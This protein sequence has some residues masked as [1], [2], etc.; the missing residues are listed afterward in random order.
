MLRLL[1]YGLGAGV[2][3]QARRTRTAFLRALDDCRGSQTATLQRL[4]ALHAGSDFSR[5]HRLDGIRT[6]RDFQRAITIADYER[7]RPYVDRMKQGEW[8]A[9]LGT[10]QKPLM[11]ATS[12][13][14]TSEPKFIPISRQYLAD[15]R[16]SWQTWGI[17]FYRPFK[18]M[19]FLHIVQLA[20]DFDR[21]RTPAGTPC[22]NITGFVQHIQN[23]VIRTMYSVPNA[24]LK[25]TNSEAK[26]YAAIRFALADPHVGM[27]MTA[28][29]STLLHLEHLTQQH[30]ESILR[31]IADG[32]LS[33]EFEVADDVR[34]KLR[35]RPRRGRAR[36]LTQR[37]N[38]HGRLSLGTAWDNLQRVAV[39]TAGSAAAYLPRVRAL[40]PGIPIRD[41]GLSASEARMTIT[42]DDETRSAPLD[43]TSHFF[44]FVPEEQIESSLPTVLLAHELEADRNYFIILTTS[45]GLYR[46]D[47]QDVVRCT[48]FQGTTPLIEFLHKG[49]HISNLTGE[50]L[51]ES[52]VVQAVS[53]ACDAEAVSLGYYTL[54]PVW[55]DPPQYRLLV[56]EGDLNAIQR[57][58]LEGEVE[59]RLQS[60]N[61]EYAEKRTSGRLRPMAIERIPAGT[62]ARLIRSRQLRPSGSLEQYK[63]PCL[64][65]DMEYRDR[66]LREH[67]EP[68][69]I[70][71]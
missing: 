58:R 40:F 54:T 46:Y 56:D 18:P 41:H 50:K 17:N 34:R 4:L 30:A 43:V 10:G 42:L 5:D 36:D 1:R 39:W 63:H 6:V 2:R 23:A 35:C 25:I 47:I 61:C 49:A 33:T 37:A 71:A 11:F 44:E 66:L 14:T 69:R 31:D 53:Q 59:R 19:N 12:S 13:G 28:N 65:P 29:P 7:A 52:Q 70:G 48:G 67:T 9:L 57:L 45:C 62:W 3:F 22:G 24:V 26:A 20:S 32:S 15:Y 55:G 27:V 60:V 68:M 8:S 21:C 51:T 64:A 16:R 38:Q